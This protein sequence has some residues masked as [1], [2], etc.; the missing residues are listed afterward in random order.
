MEFKTNN[1]L[2]PIPTNETEV[3]PNVEQNPG[4]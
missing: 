3:N 1:L 4:Y 2:F